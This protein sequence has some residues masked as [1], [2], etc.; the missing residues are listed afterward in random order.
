MFDHYELIL[1]RLSIKVMESVYLGIGSN[2]G[3]RESNLRNAVEKAEEFAGKIVKVSSVYETE[4]WG[5]SSVDQFLNMVVEIKTSLRPS[6][7]LGRLLMIESLMGRLREGK[8]YSSRIIDIDILFY[9]HHAIRTKTLEIP[10]PRLHERKFV[11]VP[12]AEIAP[13][14]VHPGLKKDIAHLLSECSDK[15]KVSQLKDF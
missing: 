15:S 11:L 7:L 13:D 5:F 6:G 1:L 14:L 10:H 8:Q 4:P 3:D 2:L 12:L 9:G